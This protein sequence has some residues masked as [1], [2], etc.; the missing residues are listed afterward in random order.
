VSSKLNFPSS[1]AVFK[2]LPSISDNQVERPVQKYQK[3]AEF[4]VKIEKRDEMINYIKEQ[5]AAME[6]DSGES[7]QQKTIA[8][9]NED[10]YLESHKFKNPH[11]HMPGRRTYNKHFQD[12]LMRDLYDSHFGS[13]HYLSK[14]SK[15]VPPTNARN[16][17]DN[18]KCLSDFYLQHSTC[19]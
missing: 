15:F 9:P 2:N 3:R 18:C 8:L 1:H 4:S 19:S 5:I 10:E 6:V 11:L 16:S 7:Q 14:I 17:S 13:D 12:K